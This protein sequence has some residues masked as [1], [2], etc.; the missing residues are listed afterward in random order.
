MDVGQAIQ[1]ILVYIR[2]Y[3]GVGSQCFHDRG[4]RIPSHKPEHTSH[5]SCVLCCKDLLGEE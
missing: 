4:P 3:Q 1:E 5:G 2:R